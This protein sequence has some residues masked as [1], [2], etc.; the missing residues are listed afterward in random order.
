MN[1]KAVEMTMREL[2]T[3]AIFFIF[4]LALWSSKIPIVAWNFIT[5]K[6]DLATQ[7]K[8]MRLA[9]EI[10]NLENNKSAT[11]PFPVNKEVGG[12]YI[13]KS[14]KV[15][16]GPPD[17][18]CSQNTAQLCIIDTERPKPRPA[19]QKIKNGNFKIAEFTVEAITNV[20]IK[21][22]ADGIITISN[23]TT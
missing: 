17:D 10:N 22:D 5:Q 3:L 7:D 15:C 19:C 13:L 18:E 11:I 8:L 9:I 4:L 14:L 16:E 1:K 20:F 12:K 2:M 23:P 6:P 21:K